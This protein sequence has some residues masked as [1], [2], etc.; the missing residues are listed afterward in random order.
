MS[1]TNK[2]NINS[3]PKE[4]LFNLLLMVE[5]YEIGTVCQSKNTRV[6]TICSSQLFQ[7]AYK[8]K[9]PRKLMT[10]N[11]SVSKHRDNYTFTDGKGNQI[12]IGKFRTEYIP[13]RQIYPSTYRKSSSELANFILDEQTLKRENPISINIEKEDIGNANSGYEIYIGRE[14]L[15]GTRTPEDERRML[16]SYDQEVREF[17]THLERPQWYNDKIK[18]FA[19]PQVDERLMKEFN[20]EIID[21]LKDVNI[22][23]KKVWQVIKPLSF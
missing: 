10:G 2:I 23:N 16:A 22:G 19:N 15:Y 4:V 17:L 3:F 20:D 8:K 18:Y 1:I 14:T 21:V 5:P 13:A 7:E 11:I 12:F 9:Y 6:R